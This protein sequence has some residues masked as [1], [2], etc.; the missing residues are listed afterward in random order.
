MPP[1]G[2]GLVSVFGVPVVEALRFAAEDAGGLPEGACQV[3]QFGCTEDEYHD[4]KHDEKVP[5][6]EV[7]EHVGPFFVL[8][9]RG[10]GEP[11]PAPRTRLVS[12]GVGRNP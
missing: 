3:R 12:Y 7:C 9:I 6:C 4:G 11:D 10:C 1:L 8:E 5:A 2:A